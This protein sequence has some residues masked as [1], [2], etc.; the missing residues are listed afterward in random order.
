MGLVPF[1]RVE[2]VGNVEWGGTFNRV[3]RVDRVEIDPHVLHG[4]QNAMG[5]LR[6]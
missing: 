6:T 4:F 1:S 2:R 3:E 5:I